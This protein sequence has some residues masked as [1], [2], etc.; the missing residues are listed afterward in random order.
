VANAANVKADLKKVAQPERRPQLQRFFKT[1]PG[2]YAE[3]DRFLGVYVPD[4]RKVAK[5]YKD[6]A[7]KEI[8]KLLQS[9]I[10]EER[11]AALIILVGQFD[12]G[13]KQNRRR[14]YDY[15]L[16]QTRYINNWDLVDLTAHK[17][18]GSWLH[19]KSKA[20]LKR[21]ARSKDLW[22][23]RIA[24]IATAYDINQNDFSIAL[25]IA[26]MLVHDE[27]DLIHKAVGW[28]LREVG[29]RNLKA[30]EAFLDRHAATMPRT[31]LRYAIERFSPQKRKHYM[32]K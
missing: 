18:V 29:K 16:S 6:L 2:E 11:L 15:Y 8:E 13:D 5:R 22:Q 9:P 19:G 28:M 25:E 14:I 24:I 26:E 1:A 12:R 27:H 4:I 10:H 21:L 3:G 31:M 30:E 32:K 7:Q 20:P 23:R 17:I